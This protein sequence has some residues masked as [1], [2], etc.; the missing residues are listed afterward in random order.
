MH[1]VRARRIG[2]GLFGLLAVLSITTLSCSRRPDNSQMVSQVQ[3]RI[4]AD[5]RLMMARFQVTGTNHTITLAG[6]V[7]S[8][9]QR[10]AAVQDA[11]RVEGVKVVVD[12]LRLSG[13]SR[14]T[15]TVLESRA[16]VAG[17]VQPPM[18]LKAP[19][20]ERVSSPDN[21]HR[22]GP[23]ETDAAGLS[24]KITSSASSVNIARTPSD[25]HLIDSNVP[26]VSA[27]ASSPPIP[28]ASS[29]APEQ[30][31]VPYGSVLQV[32]LT[33]SLSS[34][35]NEK[36]DIF[37][38]S[39]ASPVLDG[40]TVVIPEGAAVQG[41]IVEVQNAGRFNGKAELVIEAIRLGYNGKTYDLRTNQYSK[42]G[43][44]RRS[45]AAATIG[46]GA[47]LGAILG[48]ILGGGKGAAIGAVI[49]AGTGTGIQAAT[50]GATVRLPAESMLSFRLEA[51]VT[52][53][54]SSTLQGMQSSRTGSSS[55]PFSSDDRPVLKQRPGSP[56]SDPTTPEGSSTADRK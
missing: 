37:L 15:M 42:Q 27:D 44:L 43:P 36:G 25:A 4:R 16:W 47:G 19:F 52:V 53:M 7:T 48:A 20:S 23:A 8:D 30:V 10:V 5:R 29:R 9:D 56:P 49:G 55:D 38:A 28:M 11:W 12:N 21:L 35:L 40:N 26:R 33:E 31:T 22:P 54:P 3:N 17:T 45:R 46:G 24:G 6:Y 13:P 41:R 34:A 14:L 2:S 32:R 50:R 1:I 18:A 39:L 51:P